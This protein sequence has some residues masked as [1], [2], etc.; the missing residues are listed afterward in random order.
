VNV[1]INE[2]DLQA[3]VDG[4]LA[5]ADVARVE[6]AIAA[7]PALARQ[8]ERERALRA[9]LRA[10]FDPVLDEPVPA[11][12]Q[13]VLL[14]RPNAEEGASAVLPPPQAGEGRGGGVVAL[15][16]RKPR[17]AWQF[18]AYALAAS[19]LVLAVSLWTRPLLTSVRMEDGRLVASGPL[20]RVLNGSLA[21]APDPTAQASI[22][23]TFRAQDGRICRTFEHR[24]M[25]GLACHTGEGWT[26]EVLSHANGAAQGDVRQAGSAMPPEVQ[27]A[28]DA[29]LQGEPFDAAHERAARDRGWH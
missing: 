16:P 5:P 19:L 13:S 17:P 7:D 1:D 23:I 11:K 25:A 2:Q 29:R 28:L 20:A 14:D 26:I 15:H 22:G 24:E 10:A 4:E 3:Y 12:L 27:G 9:R 18:P 8:V 6:A 21:S